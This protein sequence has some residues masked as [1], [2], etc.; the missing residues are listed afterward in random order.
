MHSVEI[1]TDGGCQ[2]NP[3]IGG[4]GAVLIAGTITKDLWGGDPATTNNRMELTAAIQALSALKG[5]TQVRLHTDSQ[6]V[7]QGITEWIAGWKRKNWRTSGNEPVKNVDLWQAL[8]AQ[9]GRHQIEW[10]WIKGH[11]GNPGNER[12]DELATRGIKEIRDGATTCNHEA[13]DDRLWKIERPPVGRY[14]EFSAKTVS[15]QGDK[16]G[17]WEIVSF[18]NMGSEQEDSP[19][20]QYCLRRAISRTKPAGIGET[21]SVHRSIHE[22]GDL[23]VFTPLAEDPKFNRPAVRRGGQ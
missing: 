14:C 20:E 15:L 17:I 10:V 4:W 16:E 8:D 6:Y 19:D 18:D 9:V 2:P 21:I 5:P 12:A 23:R 22:T 11:A 1:Y 3:G 7:R 13:F